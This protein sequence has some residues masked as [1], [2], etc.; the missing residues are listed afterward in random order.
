MSIL[1]VGGLEPLKPAGLEFHRHL[2]RSTSGCGQV[3]HL[4]AARHDAA[5][6]QAEFYQAYGEALGCE[7]TT[8]QL[9]RQ[10]PDPI[11]VQQLFAAADVVFLDGGNT[12]WL[13]DC[14][15]RHDL[16]HLLKPYR[17]GRRW[18]FG[19]S[20]GAN[21]LHQWGWSSIESQQAVA[22]LGILPGG[23]APHGGDQHRDRA[24]RHHLTVHR[25]RWLVCNDGSAL[26]IQSDRFRVL[27][28][29]VSIFSSSNGGLVVKSL[30][31][32]QQG[33]LDDLY[34]SA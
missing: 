34:G 31:D 33:D 23:F 2:L 20:A 5:S 3:L 25:E 14:L 21:C 27:G 22:G 1:L 12:A 30:E 18:L 26:A 15:T 7:V 28:E 11:E 19:F 10:E 6:R 8:L 32:G 24:L 4:P 13:V 16:I 17:D 29:G 9:Y